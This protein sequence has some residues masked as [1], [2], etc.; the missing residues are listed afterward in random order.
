[1][2]LAKRTLADDAPDMESAAGRAEDDALEARVRAMAEAEP[3][4]RVT[5]EDGDTVRSLTTRELVEE[6][7]RDRKFTEEVTACLGGAL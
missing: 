1:M 3:G 4:A 2:P 5:I 6:L 7:D